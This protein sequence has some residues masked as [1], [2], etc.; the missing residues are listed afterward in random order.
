MKSKK[1]NIQIKIFHFW[2]VAVEEQVLPE[3]PERINQ[4]ES[5]ES[6]SSCVVLVLKG[7]TNKIR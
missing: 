7:T 4:D 6:S 1:I 5:L 3:R 2:I